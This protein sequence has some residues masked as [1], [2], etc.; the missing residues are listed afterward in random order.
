M[1]HSFE[2][3]DLIGDV[4]GCARSL[5]L[6][7]VKMGYSRKAGIYQHPRRQVI[8]LGDIVDRGPR[9]REA[10]HIVRDMVDAGHAQIVMGNHEFNYL[11]YL[12][13]GRPGSGMEYLRTHNRRHLRILNETLEQF[14][15]HP[16][17]QNDFLGWIME[18]PLFV[19]Q[20]QF[21]VVHAC[22]SKD[23]IDDF[24][25]RQGGNCLDDDYLHRS[26]H[27]G[28]RE[29]ETMD[30]LLRGTHLKM[31][32]GEVMV[33]K[34]GY[35]RRFFRTKFWAQQPQR[36]I[37]VVFQ[38]DPLPEHVARMTLTEQDQC[39]LLHYPL[40]DPLLFIG[41]YWCDGEPQPVAPNVACL[42]YSA[43]KYGKLVAYR[44]DQENRIDPT[45][46]IWVD[47]LKEL[48]EEV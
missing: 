43:V 46:F 37:D 13:P 24:V 27:Y 22:W 2:G 8:F 1:S 34:D 38:P 28:T 26:A 31:P 39:D 48:Q 21:R 9:I 3:F 23:H 5:E 45:K 42:D 19:E 25:Q 30:R 16:Q 12:T 11:S 18:M 29:W 14:A 20:D 32:N 17:D 4:H 47:V 7:L 6:L 10:L 35:K 15:N 33:S 36:Y 41:H 44:L 40:E